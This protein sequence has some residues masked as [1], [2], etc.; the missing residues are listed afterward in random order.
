MNRQ[1]QPISYR[2]Y[3]MPLG[4]AVVA[5]L[6]QNYPPDGSSKQD[7]LHFHNY[8]EIGYCY[9]GY[10]SM[11]LG[12]EVVPYR[13]NMFTIIPSTVP[14]MTKITDE[15]N[16][17][18]EYLL[19]DVNELLSSLYKNTPPQ[20]GKLISDI[21]C[22]THLVKVADH[23]ETAALIRKIIEVM[24]EQKELYQEEAKGLTLALL[25]RIA[26]WNKAA[27]EN[28]FP[29]GTTDN[30]IISPAL[31]Y[32]ARELEHPFK[33]KDLAQLCHISEV[34][35]RRVFLEYMKMSPVKF[36]NQMR[37]KK[38]CYELLRTN[39]SINTIASRSGFTTLSTFNRNFKQITGISPQQFR[40]H[41]ERYDPD[42]QKSASDR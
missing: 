30:T 32:I 39:N 14:H 17:F 2:T 37:I 23:Q 12:N 13:G 5:M 11:T 27:A 24:R 36:I 7:S 22:R 34:H 42:R 4:N 20:F 25:I 8:M 16:C 38:A 19:I 41:P 35:F 28:E 10:G 18:W 3:N 31:D 33:I 15:A 9:Y 29:S 40:K 1:T 21:S 6:E 26:R